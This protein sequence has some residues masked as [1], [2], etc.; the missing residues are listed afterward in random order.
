M[1]HSAIYLLTAVA[2]AAPLFAAGCTDRSA[3]NA[4]EAVDEAVEDT[5]EAIENAGD[6][7]KDATD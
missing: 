5:G 4:G 1:K 7:V 2:F 3:E 6:E